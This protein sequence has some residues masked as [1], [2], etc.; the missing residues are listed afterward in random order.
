LLY[1]DDVGTIV[2]ESWIE[3][4]ESL[5]E[6]TLELVR[7]GLVRQ[8]FPAEVADDLDVRFHQWLNHLSDTEMDHRRKCFRSGEV[9]NVHVDKWL[10]YRGGIEEVAAMGLANRR[11][12]RGWVEVESNTANEFMAAL[13]LGLCHPKSG[14]SRNS[15]CTWLPATDI[16]AAF[17]VLLTGLERT[18]PVSSADR[19]AQ[20]RLR[21]EL[22][23]SE[24]RTSLLEKALPVPVEPVDVD[25][26][27]RIRR[28][29]GD[30][31]PRCRRH[32]EALMDRALEM[33]E[34]RQ[35]RVVDRLAE[36][37]GELAEQAEAYL[38][39]AGIRRITRSSLVRMLKFVP[40]VAG[41]ASATVETAQAL[42]TA[43]GF[44]AETLAYLALAH[45]E[46][47]IE[48]RYQAASGNAPFVEML[49][50]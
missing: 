29:Y 15:G 33:D 38:R 18:E 40:A 7:R 39:E 20:R 31:L 6:P 30:M 22:E 1:W 36:E 28:R 41:A 27:E 16:S 48:G 47:E 32:V 25:R 46:M 5:G 19:D 8:V 23:A 21:G 14:L 17:R 35:L 43:G 50:P 49:K 12:R 13:A 45:A 37:V 11:P 26:I 2:P 42:E 24:V 4:P 3:R 9:A 44:Q 34:V 10:R